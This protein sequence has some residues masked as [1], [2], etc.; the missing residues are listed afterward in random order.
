MKWKLLTVVILAVALIGACTSPMAQMGLTGGDDA[1]TSA[2]GEKGTLLFS[3]GGEPN[4]KTFIPN[5][6]TEI[7]SFDISG[8]G[9][10]GASFTVEGFD[11]SGSI[12]KTLAAGLWTIQVIGNNNQETAVGSGQT[13][14]TLVSG[15]T[16][17]A[18][19]TVTP[20][21]GNGTFDLSINW[22]PDVIFGDATVSATIT[23]MGQSEESITDNDISDNSFDLSEELETGYYLLSFVLSD[24]TGDTVYGFVESVQMVGGLITTG[25]LEITDEMVNTVYSDFNLDVVQNMNDPIEI[26]MSASPGPVVEIGDSVE[27]SATP[28][29]AD[30]GSYNYS[31]YVDSELVTGET[32][33]SITLESLESGVHTVNVVIN[34]GESMSSASAQVE[35]RGTVVADRESIQTAIDNASAGDTL[36]VQPGT[37]E[38]QI[39]IDKAITLKGP[40]AGNAGSENRSAE[41]IIQG[42]DEGDSTFAYDW[43]KLVEVTV[44]GVVV[45]GVMLDNNGDNTYGYGF[46]TDA[47]DV[48]LKNSIIEGFGGVAVLFDEPGS[49]GTLTRNNIRNSLGTAEYGGDYYAYGMGAAVYTS[50]AEVSENIIGN[51]MLG[52]QIQPWSNTDSGVLE[53]NEITAYKNGIYYNGSSGSD[54]RNWQI[55]NNT[56]SSVWVSDIDSGWNSFIETNNVPN[57]TKE[58]MGVRFRSTS[59]TNLVTFEN[60]EIEGPSDPSNWSAVEGMRFRNIREGFDPSGITS[61]SISTVEVG[62][63]RYLEE[64]QPSAVDLQVL[65]DNND[66]TEGSQAFESVITVPDQVSA[67]RILE[68]T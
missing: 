65:L 53:N 21:E 11:G 67:N 14:V 45:D 51:V 58:W 28:D 17:N 40:N 61:N 62:A 57:D 18:S 16:T 13:T 37:Y 39:V 33:S 41:A 20:V 55:K 15:E 43:E 4:A 22:D 59:G 46:Y 3:I 27:L 66:F 56:I 60:N 24:D 7:E 42:T 34:N 12:E 8:S 50:V 38:E 48:V 1:E 19:V 2:E 32:E 64:G 52:V 23:P 63:R 54:D 5:E 47:S 35:S 29:P 31:W 26:S 9:P 30:D 49:G 44:D 10:E 68:G 6:S 36:Y 25:T